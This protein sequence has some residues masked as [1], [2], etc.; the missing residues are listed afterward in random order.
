[1]TEGLGLLGHSGSW[2]SA[3]RCWP[4]RAPGETTSGLWVVL[5]ERTPKRTVVVLAFVPL[6]CR[7]P[8]PIVAAACEVPSQSPK[9]WLKIS[10]NSRT[11]PSEAVAPQFR[12]S[13]PRT[14]DWDTQKAAQPPASFPCR[15][16]FSSWS[17]PL[18]LQAF[19]FQKLE[20]TSHSQKKELVYHLRKIPLRGD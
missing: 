4:L 3:T 1:M 8:Q 16:S 5:G 14:W 11:T 6:V 18:L 7:A 12:P 9:L 13:C 17:H 10:F 19:L 20:K 2:M 15:S